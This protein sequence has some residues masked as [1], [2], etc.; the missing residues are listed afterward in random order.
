MSSLPEVPQRRGNRQMDTKDPIRTLEESKTSNIKVIPTLFNIQF[1]LACFSNGGIS[2]NCQGLGCKGSFRM[3][4]VKLNLRKGK[5][6]EIQFRFNLFPYPFSS[7][8]YTIWFVNKYFLRKD[9]SAYNLSLRLPDKMFVIA[10]FVVQLAPGI[11]LLARSELKC[12][13]RSLRTLFV[14]FSRKL[15]ILKLS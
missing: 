15:Q 6:I 9:Q 4:I 2:L 14:W 3:I 10:K 11:P 5:R 8:F 1:Q 12:I 7:P 13:F